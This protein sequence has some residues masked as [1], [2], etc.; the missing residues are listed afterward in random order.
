MCLFENSIDVSKLDMLKI[1]KM[2]FISNALNNGWT[3]RK[4]TDNKYEFS[5]TTP[6]VKKEVN[7][8]SYLKQFIDHNI[9]IDNL[10]FHKSHNSYRK[11]TI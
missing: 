10:M 11:Y 8:E 5:N 7:L 4:I 2:V 1:Q 3:V 6:S 9:N